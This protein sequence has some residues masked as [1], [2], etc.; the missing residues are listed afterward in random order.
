MTETAG[1]SPRLPEQVPVLEGPL[2]FEQLYRAHYRPVLALALV[3]SGNPSLAEEVTQEAF[4]AAY[5]RWDSIDNP[6]GYVR[7]VAANQVRSWRRRRYAEVRA[8]I[9]LRNSRPP[10]IEEMP[11][12]SEKFWEA[13][14]QLPRRQAETIALYYLEDRPTSEVAEILGISESAVREHLMRGRKALA[15][16][17]GE[18][19]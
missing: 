5:R 17:I 8:L 9:R 7:T 2:P 11:P 14:R 10:S 15:T 13:V 12:T 6:A 16:Q 18:E 19:L 3:L 1:T 4:A